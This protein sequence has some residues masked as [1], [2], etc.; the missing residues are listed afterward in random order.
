LFLSLN[1]S[2]GTLKEA[3]IDNRNIETE[4]EELRYGGICKQGREQGRD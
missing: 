3:K 4:K 2:T 1:I